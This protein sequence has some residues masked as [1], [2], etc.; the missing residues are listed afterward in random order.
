MD[1]QDRFATFKISTLT[2]NSIYILIKIIANLN[3]LTIQLCEK[4][5]GKEQNI[6]VFPESVRKGEW[7][8]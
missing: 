1:G 3:N 5:F 2:L 4:I 7:I 8:E 6:K